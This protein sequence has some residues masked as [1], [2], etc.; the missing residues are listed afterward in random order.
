MSD[1]SSQMPQQ[2]SSPAKHQFN[3]LEE[4]R[5]QPAGRGPGRSTYHGMS[6]WGSRVDRSANTTGAKPGFEHRSDTQGR[7]GKAPLPQPEAVQQKQ[8]SRQLG[9]V[10]SMDETTG[11]IRCLTGK[12]EPVRFLVSE[13][14]L[15]PSAGG[16][17]G[18]E[19]RSMTTGTPVEFTIATGGE[20]QSLSATQ[21][22]VVPRF[23]DA[24][25]CGVI[26]RELRG[27]H[28]R[29]EEA[30]GGRIT[31]QPQHHVTLGSSGEAATK[32][33]APNDSPSSQQFSMVTDPNDSTVSQSD[34]G[35]GRE[36]AV[37][38]G[39]D[40]PG[41]DAISHSTFSVAFEGVDSQE[42]AGRMAVG[43]SV[44]FVMV[45]DGRLGQ[46]RA[47]QVH[48]VQ[49]APSA[50]TAVKPSTPSGAA[51]NGARDMGHVVTLKDKY[52]FLLSATSGR[53]LF[54]HF[55]EAGF[56]LASL[57]E[58][59]ELSF[60][61]SDDN[62]SG[63]DAAVALQLL[64]PGTVSAT[65]DV[66]VPGRVMGRV[67]SV[68][69]PSAAQGVLDGIA[70][71]TDPPTGL[72]VHCAFGS[73]QL[74]SG[75]AAVEEGNQVELEVVVNMRTGARRATYVGVV[76]RSSVPVEYG[77]VVSL[78]GTWGL[79][80]APGRSLDIFFHVSS[81]QAPLQ[82]A[83]MALGDELQ[84]TV[85]SDPQSHKLAA[86]EVS[87]APPGKLGPEETVG[88][89]LLSGT[90][91][92]CLT[93][94]RGTTALPGL[95]TT[96]DPTTGLPLK[97]PFGPRDLAD[98]GV[99]PGIGDE[100]S[101]RVAV[102]HTA[103]LAA[104]AVGGKVAQYAGRRATQVASPAMSGH[105]VNLKP[106][107]GFADVHASS[108]Q[109]SEGAE[110]TGEPLRV[111]F[112]T[113]EVMDKVQ[114]K[115]GD[116]VDMVLA[117]DA[118][119]GNKTGRRVRRTSQAPVPAASS[120]TGDDSA[121]TPEGGTG[122]CWKERR[123]HPPEFVAERNPNAIKYIG[124][125]VELQAT[126]E[127]KGP[128][129]S[130]GFDP[131]PWCASRMPLRTPTPLEQQQQQQQQQE[132]QQ[133]QQSVKA[134]KTPRDVGSTRRLSQGLLSQQHQHHYQQQHQQQQQQQQQRM[135]VVGG[136]NQMP[137][138]QQLALHQM[139]QQQA[140][141]LQKHVYQHHQLQQQQMTYEQMLAAQVAKQQRTR[142]VSQ[143][144]P[145]ITAPGSHQP[146]APFSA[147]GVPLSSKTAG[148]ST[149]L[150]SGTL[151][152]P[153]SFGRLSAA[154]TAFI[155]RTTSGTL[156]TAS[157]SAEPA[158]SAT[159]A[160]VVSDATSAASATSAT[161]PP[162]MSANLSARK[163]ASVDDRNAESSD[164]VGDGA[165][166]ANPDATSAQ[167][168]T[169]PPDTALFL[170]P[171]AS[172]D[173]SMSGTDGSDAITLSSPHQQQEQLKRLAS[174]HMMARKQSEAFFTPAASLAQPLP[175]FPPA[176]GE[177]GD[178]TLAT[179]ALQEAASRLAALRTGEDDD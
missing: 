122:S 133:L 48:P 87:R 9:L 121:A 34:S 17:N 150:P 155:P 81:L 120:A 79:I 86:T 40:R 38:N 75:E 65:A 70:S 148:L 179:S 30:Y 28:K 76:S 68:P 151:T 97:L 88:E 98:E 144:Q 176:D 139:Q 137:Y 165:T 149:S 78:K 117:T 164:S 145:I 153:G 104:Q 20:Q 128:D 157:T 32:S 43:Q 132:Q 37:S 25:H 63:R 161:T 4:P 22:R 105:V 52:G 175:Y 115:V 109:A 80:R 125:K 173:N 136:E 152:R 85:T 92:Q 103:V 13:L 60:A 59:A 83:E 156:P 7:W 6:S 11:Y 116:G 174:Q 113:V 64:A 33:D 168:S 1:S 96:T 51:K 178:G 95:L 108:S 106:S 23:I 77:K 35:D 129:G 138:S 101:F 44:S 39:P 42:D 24:Q 158:T 90:V 72:D 31:W 159:T 167:D 41:V 100:V 12:R 36:A 169:Q 118:R 89:D 111:Y 141:G 62:E 102:N 50:Q 166:S 14:H 94:S 15:A 26:E 172:I 163:Q 147:F 3:H 56:P 119:S 61:I 58:G 45:H 123:P 130:R 29:R 127:V 84:F 82:G 143:S 91:S 53:R 21:V 107:Y 74:P 114:L 126:R 146:Q 112:Q 73:H 47:V 99:N 110:T 93:I 16:G 170:T 69:A 18:E 55:S 160:A 8:N 131:G 124:H 66:E 171:A 162:A 57:A 134:G 2:A 27:G 140:R 71:Y 19:D 54:F 142:G 177:G 154:A 5:T 49:M 67:V 135:V 46:L 10:L